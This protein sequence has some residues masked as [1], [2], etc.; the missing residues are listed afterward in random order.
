MAVG[1]EIT[2]YLEENSKARKIVEY[3]KVRKAATI[4]QIAEAIKQKPSDFEEELSVLE[5]Y[6]VVESQFGLAK[7]SS[8]TQPP[9]YILTGHGHEVAAT[10][11]RGA[12]KK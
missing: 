8:A 3:M 1:F 2:K 10:L 7:Q 5:G 4:Y 6:E 11:G 12:V 9:V